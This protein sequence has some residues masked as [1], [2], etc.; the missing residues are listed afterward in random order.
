MDI[1]FGDSLLS[2]NMCIFSQESAKKA[3]TM[4]SLH[5][6]IL[7]SNITIVTVISVE[8]LKSLTCTGFAL[9]SFYLALWACLSSVMQTQQR[10]RKHTTS[11]NFLITSGVFPVITVKCKKMF[12]ICLFVCFSNCLVIYVW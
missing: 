12:E 10:R 3:T 8:L 9:Y 6:L 7:I 11:T 2:R 5:F 1:L 4:P